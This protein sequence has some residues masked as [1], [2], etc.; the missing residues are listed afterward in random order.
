M[1]KSYVTIIRSVLWIM[2]KREEIILEMR[3]KEKIGGIR[4]GGV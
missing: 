4:M 3:E 2:T 1:I